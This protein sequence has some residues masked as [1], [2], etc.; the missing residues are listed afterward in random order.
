MFVLPADVA[1]T[2][3]HAQR[4]QCQRG[5]HRLGGHPHRVRP[6]RPDRRRGERCT[7]TGSE[8]I[9]L[10][11]GTALHRRQDVQR[12]RARWVQPDHHCAEGAAAAGAR[13]MIPAIPG[14]AD[15]RYH[16]SDSI[17]RLDHFPPRLGIIGGGFIAVEMGHV[18][19]ARPDV[20]AFNRRRGSL[21][22]HDAEISDRFTQVPSES[23]STPGASRRHRAR[24]PHDPSCMPTGT[25]TSSTS[26]SSRRGGSS[27][28][29]LLDA[30]AGGLELHRR[31]SGRSTRTMATPVEGVWAVGDL[32]NSYQL[33]HLANAEAKVAFWNLA[34]P[35]TARPTACRAAGGLQ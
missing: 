2:V 35:T 24:R 25:P 29:T 20:H 9:T 15:V 5:E 3:R 19:R 8:H 13:P 11:R 6:H 16:T 17:M 12:G 7:A 28:A 33:K 14:L 30:A 34:H 22:H 27:T 21:R 10:L 31:W 32:A 26:C 18:Q 4:H 1:E 23:P